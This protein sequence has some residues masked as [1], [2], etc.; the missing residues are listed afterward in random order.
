MTPAT[1]LTLRRQL[2]R[3]F[4]D[5]CTIQRQVTAGEDP[6]GAPVAS[7]WQAVA[8]PACA[9]G[10]ASDAENLTPPRDS[11]RQVYQLALPFGTDVTE[12]DQVVNVTAQ[13]G[14]LRAAGPLAIT[15]IVRAPTHLLLTLEAVQ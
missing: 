1:A 8:S 12:A 4:R 13:D 7:G 10:Q 15:A 3:L 5:R 11:L 2:L 6:Y 9:F 14:T